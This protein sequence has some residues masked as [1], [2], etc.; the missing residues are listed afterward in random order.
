M[1]IINLSATNFKPNLRILK[2]YI[3]T[4]WDD[5][6]ELYDLKGNLLDKIIFDRHILNIEII[7]NNYAIIATSFSIIIMKIY[8]EFSEFHEFYKFYNYSF[9]KISNIFLIKNKNLLVIESDNKM[10]TFDINKLNEKPIQVISN[11]S[12]S[13]FNFNGNIIIFYN[14]EYIFLYHNIKGTKIY[15]LS[16]KL[17]L[18]GEKYFTKLNGKILLILLNNEILYTMNIRNMEISQINFPFQFIN[19]RINEKNNGFVYNNKNNI[20]IYINNYLCY[21]KYINN[22]LYFIKSFKFNQLKAINYISNK[23]IKLNNLKFNCIYNSYYHR[24]DYYLFNKIVLDK[25]TDVFNINFK[26][27]FLKLN[28]VITKIN[29][30]KF[31]FKK[32]LKHKQIFVDIKMKNKNK[33]IRKKNLN[34]I[35]KVNNS[36]SF[37]KQYR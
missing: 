7:N 17:K 23:Y 4:F 10:E 34:L 11:N 35:K 30:K 21:I 9:S 33:L 20:Y 28:K 12:F 8:S 36:K 2:N 16:S 22:E 6:I 15:Q 13:N 1:K 31:F 26:S 5:L 27:L 3:I 14:F 25:N 29:I 37:K 32:Q 18:P 19:E 24:G